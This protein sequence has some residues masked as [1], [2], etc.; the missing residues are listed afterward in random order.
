MRHWCAA[1]A[2]ENG[3]APEDCSEKVSVRVSWRVVA[4]TSP[5]LTTVFRRAARGVSEHLP[6]QRTARGILAQ[7]RG[8][9]AEAWFRVDGEMS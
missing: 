4:S 7:P 8:L 3:R 6:R 2:V 5:A 1:L 9:R